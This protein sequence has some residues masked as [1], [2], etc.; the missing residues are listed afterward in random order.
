[1]ELLIHKDSNFGF[2]ELNYDVYVGDS[3]YSYFEHAIYQGFYTQIHRVNGVMSG[4]FIIFLN[5]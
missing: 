3:D 5:V 2:F 4:L 1:M